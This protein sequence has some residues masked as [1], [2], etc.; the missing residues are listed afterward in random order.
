MRHWLLMLRAG[1]G[2]TWRLTS[3]AQVVAVSDGA[4]MIPFDPGLDAP[5]PTEGADDPD[6]AEVPVSATLP[7]S[8]WEALADARDLAGWT[9]ELSLWTEGE[10]W[11]ER[12]VWI[13]GRVDQPVYSNSGAPVRFSIVEAPWEDRALLP[14]P[15]QVVSAET[16][17]VTAGTACPE[18]AIGLFYPYV[19]GAP[20]TPYD[21]DGFTDLAGWPATLVEIDET[22]R[23]NF[24]GAVTVAT[25]VIAGHAMAADN[26]LILNRTTGL[27]A[28]V[29]LSRTNDLAGQLVTVAS[30]DGGDL[31]ITEGDELWAAC[32]SQAE[33]GYLAADGTVARGAGDLADQILRQSTMRYDR[34]KLPI[35]RRLNAFA[36]DTYVNTP[37]APWAIL[38]DLI[39]PGLP[40]FWRR[41]SRGYWIGVE[42]F[43]DAIRNAAP[44]LSIDPELQGGELD[45]D[46]STSSSAEVV[47]D[48]SARFANDPGLGLTRRELRLSPIPTAGAIQN[49]YLQAAWATLRARRSAT[50]EIPGVQDPATATLLLSLMARRAA[51]VRRS[52]TWFV[53]QDDRYQPGDVVA[54]TEEE[55]R[56]SARRCWITE[57]SPATEGGWMR[58]TVE[59][60][61]DLLRTRG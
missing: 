56:W 54:V 58:V 2:Q 55:V 1:S 24:T 51:S 59:D 17:P 32:I 25:L 14:D 33:G 29:S 45:G 30:V 48:L 60:M 18:D 13:D 36:I 21:S 34:T 49:P 37:T 23:D 15:A 52:G 9:A 7:L 8:A 12:R 6:G 28:Q 41:S 57:V 16:W 44:T 38:T 61:P 27:S 47:T 10:T 39:L 26:I 42:P 5:N 31:Q 50:L 19:F 20:G 4:D 40:A 43:E 35:L 3:A 22:S 11:A 46:I 53:P